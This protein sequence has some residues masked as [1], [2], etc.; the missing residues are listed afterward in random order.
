MGGCGHSIAT[1]CQ[2]MAFMLLAPGRTRSTAARNFAVGAPTRETHRPS[3]STECNVLLRPTTGIFMSIPERLPGKFNSSTGLI[4]RRTLSTNKLW[5]K[6][7]FSQTHLNHI[8]GNRYL[9]DDCGIRSAATTAI[10]TH[11]SFAF[12]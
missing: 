3:Q 7:T 11:Q 1:F 5:A 12:Y 9:L 6:N 10:Q 8:A 2:G 4:Q